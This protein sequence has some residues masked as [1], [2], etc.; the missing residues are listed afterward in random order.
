[1][2]GAQI[3]RERTKQRQLELA[4]LSK[5]DYQEWKRKLGALDLSRDSIKQAMGFAF[6]KIESAEEVK[7]DLS[8]TCLCTPVQA[9]VSSFFCCLPQ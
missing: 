9:G 6:D 8:A 2:T 7:S 5:E 1:M 4:R 3:E